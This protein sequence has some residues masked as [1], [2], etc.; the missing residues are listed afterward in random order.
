MVL[1]RTHRDNFSRYND[2]LTTDLTPPYELKYV[3]RRMLEER[4]AIQSL[5]ASENA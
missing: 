3:E 2:V 5:I 1:L 4:R